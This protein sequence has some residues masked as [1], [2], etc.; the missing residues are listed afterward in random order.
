MNKHLKTCL[1]QKKK[2]NEQSQQQG[3]D[4]DIRKNLEDM[5]VRRPDI[6]GRQEDLI[7][8]REDREQPEAAQQHYDGQAANMNR[9]TGSMAMLMFQQKKLKEDQDKKHHQ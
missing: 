6:F 1:G 2:N 8:A 3:E 5:S 7:R 4:V 9:S